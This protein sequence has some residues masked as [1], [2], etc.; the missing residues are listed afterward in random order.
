[1]PCI[2]KI[3]GTMLEEA[4]GLTINDM[5]FEADSIYTSAESAG[6]NSPGQILYSVGGF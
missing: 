6:Q 3:Y 2:G 1:M 5:W 4:T